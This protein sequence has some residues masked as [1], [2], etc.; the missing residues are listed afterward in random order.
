M[1]ILIIGKKIS[2]SFTKIN[3]CSNNWAVEFLKWFWTDDVVCEDCT[4]IQNTECV[5]TIFEI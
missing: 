3:I 1:A 5:E 2:N 4:F